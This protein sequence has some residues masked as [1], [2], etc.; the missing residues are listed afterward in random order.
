MSYVWTAD[1]LGPHMAFVLW[2]PLIPTN[3]NGSRHLNLNVTSL[4]LISLLSSE[5][6]LNIL[7]TPEPVFKW[8]RFRSFK[9]I[10]YCHCNV[11]NT[12]SSMYFI[13]LRQYASEDASEK[14][15]MPFYDSITGK[16][17][18]SIFLTIPL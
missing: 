8:M 7:M 18:L 2:A 14:S 3:D 12:I 16:K 9:D 17:S 5:E 4:K 15:G 6:L 10:L 13:I 1:W 11:G